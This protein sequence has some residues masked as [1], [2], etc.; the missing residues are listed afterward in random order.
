MALSMVLLMLYC[1]FYRVMFQIARGIKTNKQQLLIVSLVKTYES[2]LKN[3][4]DE[5]LI[6]S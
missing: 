4:I 1:H 6:N 5:K 3:L 2:R